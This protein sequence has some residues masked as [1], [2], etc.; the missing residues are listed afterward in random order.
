MRALGLDYGVRRLAGAIP[1][2]G[3]VSEL[4]CP[5]KDTDL[6]NYAAMYQWTCDFILQCDP[7]VVMIESPIQGGRSKDIG[8]GLRMAKVA[9]VLALAAVHTGVSEVHEIHMGTWKK[10]VTGNGSFN[11][12]EVAAWLATFHPTLHALC[13]SQ[14][15]I[16][17]TCIA[18]SAQ[19]VL[20]G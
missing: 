14:D 18:L 17:A 10:A 5:D 6:Q 12:A 3:F 8:T 13:A 19:T 7:D 4:H 9:A 15:G 11:K 16:D 2:M 20:A 1:S